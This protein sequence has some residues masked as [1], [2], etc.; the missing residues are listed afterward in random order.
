MN[1]LKLEQESNRLAMALRS[2]NQ[3]IIGDLITHFRTELSLNDLAGLILVSLESLLCSDADAIPWAI[4]Y[5][6]PGDLM[7]EIRRL[8]LGNLSK[9]LIAKGLMPGKDF[10]LDG[11]GKLLVNQKAEST[12]STLL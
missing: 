3:Q 10:S 8:A 11:E 2:R 12:I 4:K 1:Y 9:R 5:I 7:Q 6:I